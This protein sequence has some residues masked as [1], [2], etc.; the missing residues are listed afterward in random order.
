MK[1]RYLNEDNELMLRPSS[2]GNIMASGKKEGELSAGAKTYVKTIFKKVHLGYEEQLSGK[3]IEKGITQEQEGIDLLNIALDKDYT[4]NVIMAT[5]DY[6]KGTADIVTDKYVRD[7]KLPWSKRT[8]PLFYEDAHNPMYIWQLR[9]YMML[10]DRDIA[11]LDYCLI[12]TNPKLL[13]AWEQADLHKVNNLPLNMRIT[14]LMYERDYVL[15]MQ[16][17]NKIEQCREEWRQLKSKF[18]L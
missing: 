14:T 1:S 13:P 9:A 16:I 4:K 5:N 6:M 8:H 10:Y 17:V 12:E 15:E 2:L 7:I 3:E 18:N 11:Y